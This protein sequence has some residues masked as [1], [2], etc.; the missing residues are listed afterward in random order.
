MHFGIV[1]VKAQRDA[2]VDAFAAT[3]PHHECR[4]RVKQAGLEALSDWMRAT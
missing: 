2:L 1:A 4:A 3:W